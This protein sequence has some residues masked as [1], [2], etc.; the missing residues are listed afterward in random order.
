MHT[1]SGKPRAG[2]LDPRRLERVLTLIDARL[3]DSI[4]LGDLAAEACLSMY[5][6]ARLFHRA[7]GAPPHR[8]VTE[9][10]IQAA[11]A[12][13]ASRQASLADIAFGTGFSSQS[14]F[15]R[16]FRRTTGLTPGQ[17]RDLHG[18]T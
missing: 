11:Q 15:H 3:A 14:S 8:Y 1:D 4:S 2:T 17:Y 18:W 16:V 6:F 10:R 9:R 12:L 5:H 7:T 13:L